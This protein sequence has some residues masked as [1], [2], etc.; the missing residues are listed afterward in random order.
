MSKERFEIYRSTSYYFRLVAPN[1][2]NIGYDTDFNT[3]EGCKQG[4]ANVR[5]YSQNISNFYYWQSTQ[6]NQ[7]Y[8]NLRKGSSEAPIIL[9]SE[10]YTT[11]DAC[12]NG[13]AAVQKYAPTAEIV[14]RA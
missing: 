7:W 11:K 6:N 9:R 10:G 1:N 5:S 3:K 14:D 8:F 2:E 13:I 4:I 12:F